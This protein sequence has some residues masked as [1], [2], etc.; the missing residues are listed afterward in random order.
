MTKK[1]STPNPFQ[2]PVQEDF[3]ASTEY[4]SANR[5]TTPVNCRCDSDIANDDLCPKSASVVTQSLSESHDTTGI[6]LFTTFN[7]ILI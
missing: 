5:P 6:I 1:K 3:I 7:K 2:I 4:T